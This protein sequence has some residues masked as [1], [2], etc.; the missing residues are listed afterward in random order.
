MPRFSHIIFDLDGTLTDNTAGIR[1]SLLYAMEHMQI[2][3]YSE[4]ILE[5]SIGPPL[6]WCFS[7]LLG[8]NERDTKLAVEYFREYFGEKGWRE[9][10]PY[11][12]IYELLE[13][14]YFN[15]VKMFIATAK[16]EK[17]AQQIIEHF[18]FDKYVT[19]LKGADYGG[20]NA[21]KSNLISQLLTTNQLTPS[22][23]IVVVGDTIFD[24][25]GGKENGLATIAVT[26]GFGKEE[27]L[28]N[29]EPDFLVDSVEELFEILV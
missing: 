2:Q 16:F 13:R 10:D 4:E 22:K 23:E 26:Y 8:L 9:N 20:K 28:K 3:G 27:D 29:A 17:Y 15:G 21:T 14:L 24:I 7:N 19:Q 5:K 12:G 18:E 6:Q 11:P 25:E 1:N